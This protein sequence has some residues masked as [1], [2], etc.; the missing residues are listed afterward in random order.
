M[1][2]LKTRYVFSHSWALCLIHR[3]SRFE[4]WCM[5]TYNHSPWRA[6]DYMYPSTNLPR[7]VMPFRSQ[8]HAFLLYNQMTSVRAHVL[9]TLYITNCANNMLNCIKSNPVNNVGNVLY[10]WRTQH[11]W[12]SCIRQEISSTI[13]SDMGDE[14]KGVR[15]HIQPK[16]LEKKHVNS[17]VST[18]PADGLVPFSLS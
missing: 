15:N 3:E 13:S 1:F 10:I 17:V 6:R 8:S 18:V 14:R 9:S 16:K 12:C 11:G 5:E 4:D 7:C 2:N